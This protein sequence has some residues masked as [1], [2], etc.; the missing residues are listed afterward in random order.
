MNLLRK[1]KS[2]CEP[3]SGLARRSVSCTDVNATLCITIVLLISTIAC[4]RETKQ[5]PEVD[6]DKVVQQENEQHVSREPRNADSVQVLLQERKSLDKTVWKDEVEAQKYEQFFVQ[7]WDR[8]R[9]GDALAELQEIKFESLSFPALRNTAR[10]PHNVTQFLFDH[11]ETNLS[12]NDWSKL[13]D[14]TRLRQFDL[15]ELE[16]LIFSFRCFFLHF[17]ILTNLCP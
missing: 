14:Q 3:I 13:L 11:I 16:Y 5:T 4:K 10:L 6:V 9:N 17:D 1:L 2:D 8:I 15:E 7:L 12:W